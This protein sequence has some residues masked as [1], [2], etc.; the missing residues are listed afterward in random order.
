MKL[1]RQTGFQSLNEGIG[2]FN[3]KHKY[4]L[5]PQMNRNV[6]HLF[7][8]ALRSF[9]IHA[10][11]LET[12]KDLDLGREH[13]SGKE[14]LPCLITTGDILYFLKK[15]KDRLG[16][17]FSP[18]DYIYFMPESD[19]PC[20]FGMYNKYQRIMFD[21]FQDLRGV[22][23]GSITSKDGYS[24]DGLLEG[25]NIWRFRKAAFFAILLGDILNRILWKIRPYEKENG[26]SDDFIE[27][28]LQTLAGCFESYGAKNNFD[29]ILNRL[30]EII[31]DGKAIIDPTVAP[32]PLVGVVGEI[33]IRA[34]DQSNQYL[35]KVLEEHGAEVVVSSISEWINYTSYNSMRD[36]RAELRLNLKQMRPRRV[37]ENLKSIAGYGKDFYY[38]QFKQTRSYRRLRS[39][40]GI[41]EDHKVAH[42]DKILDRED[43]FSFD[44]GTEACLSISGMM[45][46]ADQ[47]FNGVVNVYPFTCMPG[48]VTSSIAKPLMNRYRVPYLDT[49]CDVGLQPGRE[50]AV[51]TFMYQVYQHFKRN[52]RKE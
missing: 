17:S 32:K 28:A 16:D 38:Q 41:V 25:E 22:R 13:T 29:K 45:E 21:S 18:D 9:D 49:P 1:Q 14:C 33:F 19:G 40:I 35:V 4:F 51:R 12:C 20:R 36:A 26:L 42:L 10:L 50:D 2:A 37:M 31:E 47:G 3:A 15:E 23:I 44:V 34:Q 52:G 6:S 11:V 46:Y 48:T 27:D 30:K 24:L 43:V 7:A 5:V 8:A 39:S